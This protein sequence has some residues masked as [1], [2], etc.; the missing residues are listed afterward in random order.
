[1]PLVESSSTHSQVLARSGVGERIAALA[2]G[3]TLGGIRETNDAWNRPLIV[4][5]GVD[6]QHDA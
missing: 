6:S 1:M 5:Y 4:R 2:L 3:S